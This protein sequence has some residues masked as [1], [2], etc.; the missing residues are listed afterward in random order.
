M[1]AIRGGGPE[2]HIIEQRWKDFC[3]VLV[4]A[5]RCVDWF[6]LRQFC[7]TGTMDG[8]LLPSSTDVQT[9]LGYAQA[10]SAACTAKEIMRS[11]D[12]SWF[13]SSCSTE[14]MMRGTANECSVI[15][16]M[17]TRPF[18]IYLFECGM[19]AMKSELWIACSSDGVAL[20]KPHI[21]GYSNTEPALPTIEIKNSM[22]ASSLDRSLSQST[23]EVRRCMVGDSLFVQT[24]PK[25]HSVQ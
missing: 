24:I 9:F 2:T 17:K 5:Q 23:G 18:V 1:Y 12:D 19:L 14:R 3:I 11:L 7:V 4:V 10:N 25:I 8:S 21:L 6:T 16:S 20:I 13:S 15:G 22:A